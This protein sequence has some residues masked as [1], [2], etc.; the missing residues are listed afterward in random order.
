MAR[1]RGVLVFGS[2]N[3][4]LV[5]PCAHLPAAGE[6]VA[7]GDPLHL[8]GGKG[9]NQAFAAARAGAA[10]RLA[11]S[12][13][14][15]AAADAALDGLARAGCDLSLTVRGTRPTG[16]AV[17]AIGPRQAAVDTASSSP[18]VD[19]QIIVAAGA[20]AD[21]DDRAVA[22]ADLAGMVLVTQNETPAP[23]LARLHLRARTAGAVVVHNAAPS[24]GR[25]A[26]PLIAVDWLVV[27]ETEWADL[28]GY[29]I[30]DDSA[31]GDQSEDG[32]LA[33]VLLSGR[34]ALGLR[35]DQRVVL[36]LGSRGAA[37]L[38][39]CDV[40]I[41]P[42]PAVAVV[43]ST[44]AGD[45]FVGAFAAGLVQDAAATGSAL[46]AA[47]AAGALACGAVGARSATPDAA[48]I[49]AMRAGLP[50]QRLVRGQPSAR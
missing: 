4:D 5:L 36:T 47:V 40:L 8:P 32:A 20:N 49:A 27:N 12:L 41:Q 3:L 50:P 42:A 43:D 2:V 26:P 13:G 23:A 37:V 15:D 19:N 34:D 38:D 44:G 33:A 39:G 22:D 48:A 10:T 28:S 9:G 14:D 1:P 35:A 29:A 30:G 18:A 7:A 24:R 17:V 11:A 31:G 46:A 6:T 16:I 25:D 21:L 45:A